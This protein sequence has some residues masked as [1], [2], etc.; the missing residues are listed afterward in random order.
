MKKFKIFKM[1]LKKN[2]TTVIRIQTKKCHKL[3][4]KLNN[5]NNKVKNI[6]KNSN[7]CKKIDKIFYLKNCNK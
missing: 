3:I 7:Q 6:L 1:N 2:I 5:I 4:Y